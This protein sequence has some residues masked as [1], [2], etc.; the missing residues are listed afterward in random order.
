MHG[1]ASSSP[2][3]ARW[4]RSQWPRL[5]A[6][7]LLLS[8]L[9]SGESRAENPYL[10]ARDDKPVGVDLQGTEWGDDIDGGERTL[11][12]RMTTTRVAVLPYGAV[13]RIEFVS[14]PT[15][16]QMPRALPRWLLL[17]TAQ[18]IAILESDDE[19]AT[20]QRL[21]QQASPP[22]F[23]AEAVRAITRGRRQLSHTRTSASQVS[24]TGDRCTYRYMH[25]SG[26]FTTLVWQR[27]VGLIEY[28]A[29]RGARADGVRL[30]RRAGV[31]K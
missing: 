17:A 26:H 27:G 23:A 28:A 8:L 22:P 31:T 15:Q 12:A 16:A 19:A 5:G 6:F 3:P 2:S 7:I 29:G 21:Q 24:V 30:R 18:E 9:A 14:L 20:L 10:Q 4:H 11:A 25:P 13:F 1:C